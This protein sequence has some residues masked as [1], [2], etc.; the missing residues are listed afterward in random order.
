MT[1]DIQGQKPVSGQYRLVAEIKQG[2]HLK[3]ITQY[4]R[5]TGDG[6]LIAGSRIAFRLAQQKW[7][8]LKVAIVI[9]VLGII[10][11]VL[12]R[13]RQHRKAKKSAEI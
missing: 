7:N 10:G 8:L 12:F 13:W 4:V 9:V 11:F 1:H 5:I 3:T 2:R 6:K